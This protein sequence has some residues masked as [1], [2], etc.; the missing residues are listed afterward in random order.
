MLSLETDVI[1]SKKDQVMSTPDFQHIR[2][3]MVK[4]IA[5]VEIVTKDITGPKLAQELS[6]ELTQVTQQEWA[7]QLV[8]NFRRVRYLSSTGF[9]VLF[10]LVTRGK[11]AGREVRFCNMDS[12]L[13][14]GADIVGLGTVVE[15]HDSEDSA[16]K[17]FSQS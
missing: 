16:L 4:E 17:A 15:I 2:M 14:V 7:K 13:R 12:E 11:A 5:V 6:A 3:S 1:H 8:V 9:A 10:G